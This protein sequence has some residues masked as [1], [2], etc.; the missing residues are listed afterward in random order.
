MNFPYSLKLDG[1]DGLEAILA[2]LMARK[3]FNSNF[4]HFCIFTP[5]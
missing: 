3:E 2:F 5:P 1:A 4:H